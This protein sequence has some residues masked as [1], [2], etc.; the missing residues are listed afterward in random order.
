MDLFAMLIL[1]GVAAIIIYPLVRRSEAVPARAAPPSGA[2]QTRLALT[3]IKELEFDHE[4]GKIDDDDYRALR[5]RYDARAVEAL[6]RAESGRGGPPSAHSDDA[7]A[8][9]EA[10]VRAARMRRFCTNCGGMLPKAARFC[11]AC[12]TSAEVM[13]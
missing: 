8:R 1:I 5:T 4:T 11:P 13:R 12:G 10:E 3:A 6:E 9:I 2:A 7:T